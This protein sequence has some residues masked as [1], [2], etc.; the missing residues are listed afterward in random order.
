MMIRKKQMYFVMKKF[1]QDNEVALSG[2]SESS[3]IFIG[4]ENTHTVQFQLQ[5]SNDHYIVYLVLKPENR[6]RKIIDLKRRKSQAIASLWNISD[7]VQFLGAFYSLY[8]LS[9]KRDNPNLE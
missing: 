7:V 6:K 9:A 8:W 1:A 3:M 5:W 2:N 4:P